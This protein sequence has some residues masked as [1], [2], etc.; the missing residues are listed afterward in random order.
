ML[1]VAWLFDAVRHG[2]ILE[3]HGCPLR[4][5]STPVGS[6]RAH[7]L[8]HAVDFTHR[9]IFLGGGWMALQIGNVIKCN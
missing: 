1:V 4:Q 5:L 2:L 3:N 6:G 8:P 7:K 9:I